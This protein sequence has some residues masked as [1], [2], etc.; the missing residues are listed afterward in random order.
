MENNDQELVSVFCPFE[1][2]YVN[3]INKKP[4]RKPCN[5]RL[6]NLSPGSSG[7]L[8]CVKGKHTKSFYFN[9][10]MA[11]EVKV[12]DVN[13]YSAKKGIINSNG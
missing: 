3:K 12:L 9:I 10:N 2:V 8:W 5:R 13:V 1:V 4:S 6:A 11:G 7:E